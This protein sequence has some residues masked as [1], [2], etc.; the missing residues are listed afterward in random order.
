MPGFVGV[1]YGSA[2][3]TY[4]VFEELHDA[5]LHVS[6]VEGHAPL[7]VIGSIGRQSIA[8]LQVQI[9]LEHPVGEFIPNGFGDERF[10]FIR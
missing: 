3:L 1:H 10:Q 5:L 9:V 7:L 8:L 4:D 2:N 6:L